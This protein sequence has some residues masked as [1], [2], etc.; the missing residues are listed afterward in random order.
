[1]FNSGFVE[2]HIFF[3]KKPKCRKR[4]YLASGCQRAP[5]V[6]VTADLGTVQGL[7]PFNLLHLIKTVRAVSCDLACQTFVE[8]EA[9]ICPP[10]QPRPVGLGGVRVDHRNN[11]KMLRRPRGASEGYKQKASSEFR[12]A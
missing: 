11:V 6:T 4:V 5:R 10:H 12:P 3:H 9:L 7:H 8:L 1:M 2:K